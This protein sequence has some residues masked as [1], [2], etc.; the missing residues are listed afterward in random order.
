VCRDHSKKIFAYIKRL[1]SWL[2]LV[3]PQDKIVDRCAITIYPYYKGFP[4]FTTAVVFLFH[5]I[6]LIY[7]LSRCSCCVRRWYALLC[8]DETGRQF[9][10]FIIKYSPRKQPRQNQSQWHWAQ[11]E[12]KKTFS[13][14][15]GAEFKHQHH[16]EVE[17]IPIEV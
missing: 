7:F 10:P 1:P 6:C 13:Y 2:G 5:S 16:A 11:S 14:H 4:K 12:K 8:V 17:H 9:I 3:Q 15:Q